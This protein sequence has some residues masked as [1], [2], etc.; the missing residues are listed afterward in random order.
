MEDNT[1][2]TNVNIEN[3]NKEPITA[4][5]VEQPVYSQMSLEYVASQVKA[6]KRKGRI[7]GAFITLGI[8]LLISLTYMVGSIIKMVANGSIYAKAVS[9][10]GSGILD[11][12]TVDK[13]DEIYRIIN[14][15]FID[16][17]DKDVIREGMYRGMLE[18]LDDPYSVYYS[19]EEYDEMMES[20][21]GV[22][23]GIGAYLSTDPDTNNVYIVRPITGSPAEEAGLLADDVIIEVDGEN[24]EGLD[25]NVVVSK[26]R[27]PKGTTVNIG[28]A[29]TGE[30]DLIYFDVKRDKINEESVTGELLEDNIGHIIITEFADATGKQFVK[31][32]DD[33][34]DQ[35]M[36]K[37]IVDL[38]SN[39]GGYVDTSVE[40]ADKLVEE[41]AIVSIKDR[42]GIGYT[43]E[44]AGDDNFITIPCVFLVDGNT[45]S[46]SEILTGA[47]K[48]Y[49][50]ATVIG[51]QTFGKGI[52]QDVLPLEDGSGLKITNSKYYTPNGENIHKVGITPDYIVE[53]DGQRYVDEGIDNQLEA[54]KSFLKDGKIDSNYLKQDKASD[55]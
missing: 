31:T 38:R 42:R 46:A 5:A 48:D 29:R 36:E 4:K 40:V 34:M 9:I 37:L 45:A 3:N 21:S 26:V 16:E 25:I 49:G 55:K 43:Y 28:V 13:V 18:A 50:I 8:V 51:T 53:W 54:A 12:E 10:G 17:V 7:Q 44:D 30:S 2:S 27:G 14:N 1:N 24:V 33:L 41:G 32:Y 19:K 22:F 6:A 52:V 20:S 23:E 15:T 11:K 47:V 35:G 39:G